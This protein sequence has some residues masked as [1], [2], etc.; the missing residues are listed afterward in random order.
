MDELHTSCGF[1]GVNYG[2]TAYSGF[3][4]PSMVLVYGRRQRFSAIVYHGQQ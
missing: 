1:G 2:R 3:G 4:L